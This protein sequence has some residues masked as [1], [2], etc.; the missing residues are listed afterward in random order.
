MPSGISER[1]LQAA[2][3]PI[4]LGG[5]YK[6]I[7]SKVRQLAAEEKAYRQQNLKSFL[8]DSAKL[9]EATKAKGVRADD[10]AEI[11]E[12]R[13]KWSQMKMLQDSDPMLIQND[14]KSYMQLQNKIDEEFSAVM[15]LSKRSQSQYEEENKIFKEMGD[16]PEM[17]ELGARE[18]WQNDV[19]KKPLSHIDKNNTADLSKYTNKTPNFDKM[20]MAYDKNVKPSALV[21]GDK[22]YDPINK[23]L[24]RQLKFHNLPQYRSYSDEAAEYLR[25]EG[26][27]DATAYGRKLLDGVTNAEFNDVVKRFKAV[28]GEG[29]VKS[30]AAIPDDLNMDDYAT[31][32]KNSEI[33]VYGTAAT[34]A[35]YMAMKK[36][37]NHYNSASVEEP[38]F[39][40]ESEYDKMLESSKL[41][42]GRSDRAFYRRMKTLGLTDNAGNF[43]IA[44]VFNTISAGG[45]T[46][47]SQIKK[48][49]G[50]LN[51]N[52]LLSVDATMVGFN[53]DAK[54]K[55]V[56]YAAS[57]DKY[58]NYKNS[59]KVL[60]GIIGAG[61]WENMT[62][63]QIAQ[64]L[65]TKNREATGLVSVSVNPESVRTGKIL[66]FN[67]YNQAAN[68]PVTVA[69]D[70]QD[71]ASVEYFNKLIKA[72][73]MSKKQKST[74]A[75]GVASDI[76]GAFNDVQ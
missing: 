10:I 46:G 69:L 29:S 75:F 43:D 19:M 63:E 36:F 6:T 23:Q 22:E 53:K 42:E 32:D 9:T 2:Y 44:P 66:S 12:H 16:K 70:T 65:E 26:T 73:I 45:E 13:K 67:W 52:P 34:A 51:N 28:K 37:L 47:Q 30:K 48:F 38:E 41:S 40:Y 25:S 3:G 56:P 27:H 57:A 55:R 5:V 50:E 33:S 64:E 24:S 18:R 4:D 49:I 72:K 17:Y 61:K 21:L 74:A 58:G 1:T 71:P 20:L 8:Q 68:K 7:E 54:G 59:K 14:T 31:V 11:M 35:K 15:N 62:D 76:E 39:K 60:D